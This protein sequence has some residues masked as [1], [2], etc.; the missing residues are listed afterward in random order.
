VSILSSLL[1]CE[2]IAFRVR[3]NTL[4]AASE[5]MKYCAAARLLLDKV[6]NIELIFD[7]RET[8]NKQTQA[9][10]DYI[11]NVIS[12]LSAQGYSRITLVSG[13]YPININVGQNRLPRNDRILWEIINSKLENH[14]LGYGDYTVVSPAWEEGPTIRRGKAAIRYTLNNEWLVIKGNDA[15]KNESIRL[16]KILLTLYKKDVK[17]KE[18]SFGDTLIANR[19]DDTLTLTEKKGGAETHLLEGVNH[20]ITFVVKEH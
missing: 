13:A 3:L 19:A 5:L 12:S 1:A 11:T 16:S 20:H 4:T 2:T 7:L 15:T 8:P 17:E 6:K 18:Y 9:L 10:I 14:S